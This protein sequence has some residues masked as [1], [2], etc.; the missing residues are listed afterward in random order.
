MISTGIWMCGG[1]EAH[2]SFRR[3]KRFFRSSRILGASRPIFVTP[4]FPTPC[5]KRKPPSRG[6]TATAACSSAL[7]WFQCCESKFGLPTNAKRGRMGGPLEPITLAHFE[8]IR[9]ESPTCRI[10]PSPYPRFKSK[11]ERKLGTHRYT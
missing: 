8:T 3:L 9:L 4:A 5:A 1:Q 11:D 2:Q 6:A 7:F 10:E